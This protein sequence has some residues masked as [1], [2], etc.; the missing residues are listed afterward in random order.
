MALNTLGYTV[1]LFILTSIIFWVSWISKS[2]H[3]CISPEMDVIGEID[4][5]VGFRPVRQKD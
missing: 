2:T 4:N 3:D 1:K 5:Y